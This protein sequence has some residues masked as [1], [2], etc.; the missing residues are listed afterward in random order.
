MEVMS[1]PDI[2][3]EIARKALEAL[4]DFGK[5]QEYDRNALPEFAKYLKRIADNPKLLE[6][7][8]LGV[9]FENFAPVFNANRPAHERCK[10]I[11]SSFILEKIRSRSEFFLTDPSTW[12]G[13]PA[14]FEA[15]AFCALFSAHLD[16]AQ[17]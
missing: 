14:L 4:K 6:S 13:A 7:T 5:N 12:G 16:D 1:R 15:I 8:P 10:Q 17:Q 2:A 9:F 3:L 11:D